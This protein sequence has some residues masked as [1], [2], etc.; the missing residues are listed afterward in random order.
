MKQYSEKLQKQLLEYILAQPEMYARTQGIFNPMN[1]AS[2]LRDSAKYIQTYATK[3]SVLPT[4]AQIE[5]E[6]D[7]IFEPFVDG[8][9]EHADWFLETFENFTKSCELERAI[10]KSAELLNKGDYGPV[11]GL[12]KAA[13]QI[14]LIKNIGIDYFNNPLER[15]MQIKMHN[16]QTSTGWTALDRVLYGGFDRGTLNIF[17]GASGSGKSLCLMNLAVNWMQK[18]LNGAYITLELSEQYCSMRIDSMITSVPMRDIFSNLEDVAIR[19]K[20]KK[21]LMGQLQIKAFP[22]QTLTKDLKSFIKEYHIQTGKT[23]DFI[24]VD[25]LD[26][27]MPSS[28]K[29][30]PTNLF[31][32]DKLVSEELRNMSIENNILLVTASQ[33]GRSAIDEV[34]LDHAHIAGGIS[35]IYTADNVFGIFTT[36]SMKEKGRYQLQALKTRNSGG[37]G[38]KIDLAINTDTLRITDLEDGDDDMSALS[39]NNVLNKQSS[40]TNPTD[41]LKNKLTEKRDKI[42]SHHKTSNDSRTSTEKEKTSLDKL[43][44]KMKKEN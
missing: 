29:I 7:V 25:Y 6:T 11:E 16:S 44:S 21:A 34:E 28:V 36:K 8:K 9:E 2:S 31:M 30:D 12:I 23:F 14:G 37:Q 20:M 32:R 4:I 39:P 42:S 24:M 15:L 17:S 43:L 10:L 41:E 38:T 22:A 40:F 18:G 33:L 35:K 1:F 19:V 13:V 27:M 5:A 26:L 3:H